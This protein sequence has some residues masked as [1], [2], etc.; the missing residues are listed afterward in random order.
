ML[1]YSSIAT[2]VWNIPEWQDLSVGTPSVLMPVGRVPI[3]AS[4]GGLDLPRYS[5]PYCTSQQNKLTANGKNRKPGGHL[6]PGLR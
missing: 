4:T 1:D 2:Q 3:V 5:G 6:A